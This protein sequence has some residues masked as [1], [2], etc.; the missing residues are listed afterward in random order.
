MATTL[1][2]GL[3][4]ACLL[5]ALP[6]LGAVLVPL[7]TRLTAGELR[8][9]IDVAGARLVVEAPLDG[10]EAD[11][12]PRAA[13]DPA[14]P[15]TLLFTSGTTGSPKPV[16]LS[17]AN[18]RASALA[19]AWNLGVAPGDRWLCVL[20]LFHVGGLSILL[21]SAIYGTT[22]IVHERFDEHAVA[23]TLTAGQ[24]TLV[25][26][27][28]TM[29]ARVLDAGLAA[30]PPLRAALIGGGPVPGSLLA[31]ARDAGV[32]VVPT[33]GMTETA[34]QIATAGMQAG[35]D[36]ASA[37]QP[38]SGVCV[39]IAAGG[40]ILVRGAM[41]SE[42]ALA[43][44]GWLH[45]GDRGRLDGDGG[46]HVAGRIADVIVTGGE[47]VTSSEVEDVL[48][49]HPAVLDVAVVGEDDPEWGEAVTA[50]VVPDG[51]DVD[52]DELLDHVRARLA[53]FKVPKSLRII[54][55]LPRGP[56]GKVAR[57]ELARR[58]RDRDRRDEQSR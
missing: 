32:P 29:L 7:N 10:E 30:A 45:T 19:S 26:L 56:A 31:R 2:A 40:E 11:V 49:D 3:D 22:A 54:P 1:P 27:V 58:W 53:G 48:R 42:G 51:A 37:A 38:L 55:E 41:V 5:H 33:Y 43:P 36:V 13:V 20:P 44:D 15:Q 24:A 50:Y 12:E 4:F 46:L 16:V 34:S 14:E 6:R 17:Y 23:A 18:H 39:Q 52:E 8:G 25:S 57:A 9:Q 35:G 47:N 21:R 28:A